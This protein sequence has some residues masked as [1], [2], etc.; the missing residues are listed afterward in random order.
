M[1]NPYIYPDHYKFTEEWFD[2]MIPSW[3]DFFTAYL[4]HNKIKSI[5]E[6]GCYEGR[7]TTYML[8]NHLAS[9]VSYDIVDTFGGTLEESGMVG[10]KDRLQD[11]DFI[12][13]NF[14]HNMDFHPDIDLT[15]Y[16]DYSHYAL[17]KLEQEGKKYDFIYID[18]SHRVDDTYVDAYYAHKML[19]AGGV[20]IFDDFGWKD[21]NNPHIVNSPELGIRMFFTMYDEEYQ[22]ALQGYQIGA[23]KTR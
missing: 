14:K 8:D 21:P 10:T 15:I 9:D 11:S 4:T 16:R 17:P 20:I 19:N 5:L 7:A 6:V 3:N 1:N 12:Y 13:D 18:A 2:P 23:V 22:M